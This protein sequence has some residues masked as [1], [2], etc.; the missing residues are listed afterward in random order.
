[1]SDPFRGSQT[2]NLQIQVQWNAL[3]TS[4]ETGDAVI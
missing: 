4:S 1:M 2:S 3:T